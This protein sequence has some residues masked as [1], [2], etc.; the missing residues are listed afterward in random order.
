MKS[1]FSALMLFQMFYVLN[2][3]AQDRNN[4]Y[5]F[6]C[7]GFSFESSRHLCVDKMQRFE[8][9]NEDAAKICGSLTFDNNKLL[10]LEDIGNKQFEHYEIE[11][12]AHAFGR[13]DSD[14][15]NCLKKRGQFFSPT[16]SV[17]IPDQVPVAEPVPV[18]FPQEYPHYYPSPYPR[19]YYPRYHPRFYHHRPLFG[20]TIK[21]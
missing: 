9:I 11:D 12:C 16:L 4:V 17:Y 10:C 21:L 3:H 14:I 15:I 2:V 7:A 20:L 6:V 19:Y 5:T 1:F 18:Y 13:L 8:Y